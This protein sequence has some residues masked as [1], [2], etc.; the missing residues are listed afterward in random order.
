MDVDTSF[1][2]TLDQTLW[3]LAGRHAP[4]LLGVS[5]MNITRAKRFSPLRCPA[6]GRRGGMTTRRSVETLFCTANDSMA[7]SVNS[8]DELEFTVTDDMLANLTLSPPQKLTQLTVVAEP[9]KTVKKGKRRE[10]TKTILCIP[11]CVYHS[12]GVDNG[13]LHEYLITNLDIVFDVAQT[14]VLF[15]VEISINSKT[16]FK[17]IL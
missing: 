17:H 12:P 11:Q 10:K 2:D 15:Y 5:L 8:H 4:V 1:S 14:V 3:Y 9:P 6:I 13:S 16:H 7:G